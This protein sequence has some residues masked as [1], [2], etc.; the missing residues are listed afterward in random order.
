M[1]NS[2][3]EL[4]KVE[5]K[6]LFSIK[7]DAYNTVYNTKKTCDEKITAMFDWLDKLSDLVN[8]LTTVI[9]ENE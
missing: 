9:M 7:N 3:K 6:Q 1:K 2:F 5:R 4:I 8:T